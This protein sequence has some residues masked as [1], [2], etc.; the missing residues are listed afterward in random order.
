[1]V[2]SYAYDNCGRIISWTCN[3]K[4]CSYEYD[5]IGQL[6]RVNDEKDPR[7][8]TDGTTWTYEYDNGGNITYRR[9]YAYMEGALP[10]A[11][12]ETTAYSYAADWKDKLTGY[13]VTDS[14]NNTTETTIGSDSIGNITGDGT[15]SYTWQAGRRLAGMTKTGTSISYLYDENGQ[16]IRK[17]VTENGITTDTF[18]TVAEKSVTHVRKGSDNLHIFYA[19]GKPSHCSYNG[20]MYSYVYSLQGDVLGLKNSAGTLVVTYLYDAWGKEISR[21]GTLASTLGAINPF[22]YR[23]YVFD[24]ETGLYYVC[25][26]YYEYVLCRWINADDISYLLDKAGHT[27]ENLFSYCLNDPVAYSDPSGEFAITTAIFVG[28]LILSAVSALYTGYKMREAGAS[29]GDTIAY[30]ARNGLG[31]FCTVYTLGMCTYEF[32]CEMC[33]YYGYTPATHI[34]SF[35]KELQKAADI[36]NDSIEGFGHVVGTKK[37]A[38]FKD[39][40][41]KY[42][43]SRIGTEVS[44]SE[45][46]CVHHGFSNSIRFDVMKYNGRGYPLQAWDFKTG[47]AILTPKRIN[48]MLQ[49]SGLPITIKMIK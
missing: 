31:T 36:A 45:G 37:H 40:V 13:T 47:G 15:W 46:G 1:M 27:E 16:R 44:F 17:S 7:G 6:I 33:W 25:S 30:S 49:K 14:N 41:D 29:W 39:V 10:S 23:G 4:V 19:N 2:Q 26:R 35:E 24:G 48:T 12:L 42:G 11:P 9:K 34:G 22:R 32:Y 5:A 3:N 28:S 21:G 8:G 18:Y 20:T 43:N 38:V